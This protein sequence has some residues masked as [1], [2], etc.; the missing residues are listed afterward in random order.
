M[1]GLPDT[2]LRCRQIN[3]EHQAIGMCISGD[4]KA[5][6][7]CHACTGKGTGLENELITGSF[8]RNK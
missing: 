1:E 7:G 4:W 5:G 8:C 3:M 6:T 2:V